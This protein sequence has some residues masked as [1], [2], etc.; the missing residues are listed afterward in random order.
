M[1]KK[2]LILSCFD[3]HLVHVLCGILKITTRIIR[4]F[5]YS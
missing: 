3:V 4:L 5:V 1:K 2:E